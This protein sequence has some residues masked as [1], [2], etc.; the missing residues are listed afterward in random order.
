M[1][2]KG[3]WTICRFKG[4]LGKKE[5]VV[6]LR[7]GVDTPMHIMISSGTSSRTRRSIV[8]EA[9]AL[10]VTIDRRFFGYL[11]PST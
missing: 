11:W 8:A 5:G 4:G 2:K 1:P 3:P 10:L 9:L 6:F 7:G